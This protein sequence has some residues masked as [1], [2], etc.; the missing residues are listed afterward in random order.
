M[1]P[2]QLDMGEVRAITYGANVLSTVGR[3][4]LAPYSFGFKNEQLVIVYG[5]NA[6]GKETLTVGNYNEFTDGSGRSNCTVQE[7]FV[8][9]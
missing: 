3:T 9:A 1:Q 5:R 2:D 7:T 8:R 6:D 4:V